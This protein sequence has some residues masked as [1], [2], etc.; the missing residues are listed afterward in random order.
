MK[1]LG[2]GTQHNT[3]NTRLLIRT[4]KYVPDI[5]ADGRRLY[6]EKIKKHT[7]THTKASRVTTF[8]LTFFRTGELVVWYNCFIYISNLV[9]VVFF[10]F[11]SRL[12]SLLEIET[13]ISKRFENGAIYASTAFYFDC[14][15]K[16]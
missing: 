11:Y 2:R 16:S 13:Y 12:S 1:E 15:P 4:L 5:V 3:H 8:G 7:H 9:S 6:S 14:Y 10:S